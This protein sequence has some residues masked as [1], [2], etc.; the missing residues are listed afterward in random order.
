MNGLT[1]IMVSGMSACD[2]KGST[3]VYDT[4][5]LGVFFPLCVAV[6][7]QDHCSQAVA[8]F[9]G[10]LPRRRDQSEPVARAIQWGALR[11]VPVKSRWPF[12]YKDFRIHF[13]IKT[14]SRKRNS[15]YKDQIDGLVQE[16]FNSSALAMA[17][18]LSC[19]NP[20][21]WSFFFYTF[22]HII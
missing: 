10:W 14:I 13:N 6:W 3:T 12:Q 19:T 15:Y 2:V 7:F 21:R 8:L 9:W 5:N 11:R 4:K 16:R 18:R 20:S 1:I 17:L 22:E